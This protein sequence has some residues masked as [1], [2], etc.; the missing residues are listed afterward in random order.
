[1]RISK[2]VAYG[3]IG[4]A[5]G[6]T[7]AGVLSSDSYGQGDKDKRPSPS[8]HAEWKFVD[9]KTIVVD[10]SSPRMKGRK[11][12]GDLVP[13]GEVWRTGANEATTFVTDTDLSVGGK[14][15]PAGHYTLFTIPDK[16]KWTLIIS[17]KT[18]E[19]G[20]PYP[21]EGSDL[22]RADMKITTLPA[23]EENFTISFVKGAIGTTMRVDWETTRAYIE[24]SR[25]K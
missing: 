22:I 19:W 13:Y 3:M 16:N 20:I 17:T 1:M 9:G 11:I 24:I 18:G 12:Y 14:A 5:L 15:V 4:A 8:A 21:G 25:Q 6:L 7:V 10:Y 23:P 2:L